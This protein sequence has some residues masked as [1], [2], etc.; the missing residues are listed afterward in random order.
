MTSLEFNKIT[1]FDYTEIDSVSFKKIDNFQWFSD[2]IKNRKTYAAVI[3]VLVFVN[4]EHRDG[5]H[6][7]HFI[8]TIFYGPYDVEFF[9]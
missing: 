3:S 9:C 5:L 2:K 8:W 1:S 6:E 4:P 7:D